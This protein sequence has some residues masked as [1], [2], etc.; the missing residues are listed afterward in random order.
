MSLN[1]WL[2]IA[3]GVAFAGAFAFSSS[4]A[5]RYVE[6]ALDRGGYFD[7]SIRTAEWHRDGQ[8]TLSEA[9]PTRIVSRGGPIATLS[10]SRRELGAV[11]Y[12][13][14]GERY[15]LDAFLKR[16]HTQ[17]IVVLYRGNL[18]FERYYD[19]A[20][21]ASRFTSWSVAKSLTAT[22]VGMALADGKIRSLDDTLGKYVPALRTTAYDGVTI[23]Q[24]LRMRSGI[25]FT[26]EYAEGASDIA[27]YMQTSV[28]EQFG[29]ADRLAAG[30]PLAA[31][32]GTIF[33]Y[34]TAETQI[35]GWLVREVTNKS[36]AA[37]LEEKL[38]RPLG[39][40]H[41]ASIVLDRPGPEGIEMAGCCLN[42]S[43]RDW[44]R[45]GQL[46]LQRGVW[47]GKQILAEDW[48]RRATSPSG[49]SDSFY[50]YQWWLFD[51]GRF[52]AEGV[53]GQFIF[54]D[55]AHDLV[56]AKASVWPVA[57]D[58]ALA[59]E[60]MAAFDAAGRHLAATDEAS[61]TNSPPFHE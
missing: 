29:S 38:W 42:A 10:E 7:P 6:Q 14:A 13:H 22:L 37:Y 26:E 52:S 1:R 54:V 60:A 3:L 24:A 16:N 20:S 41:D 17:G 23:D 12:E 34:N 11:T 58:D 45:F 50:G 56:I 15:T 32:P 53:H 9:F 55:P 4:L 57:W 33:N 51:E 5:L 25:A 47:Q 39:M 18:V 8:R 19:G 27:T 21:D 43:L 61:G 44:A 49:E 2:L 28:I 36:H 40:E 59:D 46:H 31:D 30:Y 35:L 48:V